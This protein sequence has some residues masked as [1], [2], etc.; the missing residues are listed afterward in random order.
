MEEYGEME[1]RIASL[2]ERHRRL[3]EAIDEENGRP[4][5]NDFILS[6]LKRRKLRIKDEIVQLNTPSRAEGA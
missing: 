1:S 4:A 6:D 5:P 2:R 3:E